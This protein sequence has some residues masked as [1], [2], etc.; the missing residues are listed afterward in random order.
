MTIK[1]TSNRE[2]TPGPWGYAP[3]C[4]DHDAEVHIGNECFPFANEAD[5][6][7]VAAA[8]ELLA[9]LTELHREAD[10]YE[11]DR[12]A[13]G[14]PHPDIDLQPALAAIAKATGEGSGGS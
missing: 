12:I 8:P 1:R 3:S 9:A 11:S 13:S 7:L 4:W 14:L 10:L 2:H 5:A 6:R